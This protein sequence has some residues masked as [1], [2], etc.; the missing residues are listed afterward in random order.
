MFDKDKIDIIRK[1]NRVIFDHEIS[2]GTKSLCE[3]KQQEL[4]DDFFDLN[5][6]IDDLAEKY[7]V[8]KATVLT[9]W[10]KYKLV[11]NDVYKM[12]GVK[13]HKHCSALKLNPNMRVEIYDLHKRG[14][15][16]EYIKQRFQVSYG[17]VVKV[18]REEREKNRQVLPQE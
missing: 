6:S 11:R 12:F 2:G 4:L 1:E 9:L 18:I 3:E 16:A 5:L 15:S 14:F 17:L 8:S 13:N 10:K 7:F